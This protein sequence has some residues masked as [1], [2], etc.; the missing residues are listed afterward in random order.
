MLDMLEKKEIAA[1][2]ELLARRLQ[3]DEDRT[4]GRRFLEPRGG[5]ADSQF[6]SGG[7]GFPIRGE[8]ADALPP[9]CSFPSSSSASFPSTAFPSSS[10]STSFPSSSWSSSSSS[11]SWS[12]SSSSSSPSPPPPPPPWGELPS[13]P[14]Y[15][16][17]SDLSATPF[18]QSTHG[19]ATTPATDVLG[20][21]ALTAVFSFASRDAKA[22]T[23]VSKRFAYLSI[24]SQRERTTGVLSKK[25][26]PVRVRVG[27]ACVGGCVGGGGGYF[28]PPPPSS[29]RVWRTRSRSAFLRCTTRRSAR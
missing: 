2:D 29:H 6:A 23:L 17:P 28:Q 21:D 11:A 20:D 3:A 24:K 4:S 19:V 16:P 8:A 5:T 10:S 13:Y 22:V 14:S 18:D 12:S 26:P 27:T 7:F 25:I 9:N 1:Q 15:P